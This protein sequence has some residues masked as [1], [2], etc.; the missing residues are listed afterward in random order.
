MKPNLA[1]STARGY[2]SGLDEMTMISTDTGISP[3]VVMRVVDLLGIYDAEQAE[4]LPACPVACRESAY[5]V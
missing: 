1:C 2:R 3:P 4:A 5:R